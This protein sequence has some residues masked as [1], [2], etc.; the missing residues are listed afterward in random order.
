MMTMSDGLELLVKE[1]FICNLQQVESDVWAA[2][3]LRHGWGACAMELARLI[4]AG[5]FAPIG[6]SGVRWGM[7]RNTAGV[8]V[9]HDK[10]PNVKKARLLAREVMGLKFTDS[11]PWTVGGVGRK[12]LAWAV[13]AQEPLHSIEGLRYNTDEGRGQYQYHD[14]KPGIYERLT[15][16]DVSAYYYRL[17]CRAPSPHVTPTRRGLIWGVLSDDQRGRWQDLLTALGGEGT[18]AKVT[19]N[20]LWG[21]ML[22][23][24]RL[25]RGGETKGQERLGGMGTSYTSSG[26][27]GKVRLCHYVTPPGPLRPLAVLLARSAAELCSVASEQVDS[28]Y[29]TVDS[30]TTRGAE[31]PRVWDSVGLPYVIKAGPAAG[32]IVGCGIWRIG[33]TPTKHY[34]NAMTGPLGKSRVLMDNAPFFHPTPPHPTPRHIFD[35]HYYREWL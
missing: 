24:T 33:D 34:A 18:G 31:R 5:Q 30:V 10:M 8:V 25:V 26:T 12:M 3:A 27:P 13:P 19:R 28:V 6:D 21:A 11:L 16:W 29:S 35:T 1:G 7:G 14:C 20:A 9:C 4:P 2:T 32:H 23:G 15:H 17:Y 22:G